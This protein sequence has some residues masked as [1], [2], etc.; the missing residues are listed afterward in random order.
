MVS[1]LLDLFTRSIV[2][3]GKPRNLDLDQIMFVRH[4]V[5]TIPLFTGLS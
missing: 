3:L 2:M 1:I 4:R 5:Y